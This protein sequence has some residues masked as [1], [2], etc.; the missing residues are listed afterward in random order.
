MILLPNN[1]LTQVTGAKV[2][3]T[4]HGSGCFLYAV[5]TPANQKTLRRYNTK[6]D[7]HMWTSVLSVMASIM[8]LLLYHQ[9]GES[10]SLF[11]LT[12]LGTLRQDLGNIIIPCIITYYCIRRALI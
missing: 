3:P 4:T 6:K 1:R 12:L 9:D 7:Y 5:D 2:Y 10:M 8:A 11:I